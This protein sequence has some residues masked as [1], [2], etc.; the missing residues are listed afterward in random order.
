MALWPLLPLK[1]CQQGLVPHCAMNVMFAVADRLS[2]AS[3][4]ETVLSSDPVTHLPSSVVPGWDLHFIRKGAELA[5][6]P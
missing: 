3:G 4:T 1:D 5:S 2:V 6:L